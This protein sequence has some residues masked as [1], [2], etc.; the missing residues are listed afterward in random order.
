MAGDSPRTVA[1][2]PLADPAATARFG[3][4]LGARLRPGDALALVGE[5]GAGK[6]AL[7][8]GVAQGLGVDD[9]EAVCSPTYLLVVEHAGPVRMLHADA[10]LPAKLAAFLRDGGLEYLFEP[11]AV[12][13]VEWADRVS[14]LMPDRTLW[15]TLTAEGEAVRRAELAAVPAVFPWLASMPKIF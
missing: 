14:N 8:R 7:A 6:T 4:W 13:V 3:R 10:Y 15:V 1:T 5:L 11:A 9:P 12:A 2:V